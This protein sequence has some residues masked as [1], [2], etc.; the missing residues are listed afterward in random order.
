MSCCGGKRTQA[1][2]TTVV[3]PPSNRPAKAVRYSHAFFRY[4]GPTAL[5]VVGATG[6]RYHFDSTGAVVAVDV[7]DQSSLQAVPQLRQ[8]HSP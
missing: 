6:T 1:A 7:R 3:R 8:V 4:V 2:Q 5:T